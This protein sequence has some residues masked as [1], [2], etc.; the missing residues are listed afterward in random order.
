MIS[1]QTL[2]AVA[3]AV[4]LNPDAAVIRGLFPDLHFT[5]CSE[6]DISPRYSP[7]LETTAHSLL[8]VTGATGH[9]LSLTNDL[10][11][12][13]GVVIATKADDDE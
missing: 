5:E 3:E 7:Q 6:D 8:L 10:A 2:A 13:T 9:C 11:A 4:Q 12:A 1:A